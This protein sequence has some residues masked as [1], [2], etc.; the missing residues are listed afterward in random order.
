MKQSQKPSLWQTRNEL[1]SLPHGAAA[2]LMILVAALAGVFAATETTVLVMTLVTAIYAS[3]LLLYRSPLVLLPVPAA[4]LIAFFLYKSPLTALLS[5]AFAPCAAVIAVSVF[6][7]RKCF[8][9]TI[10]LTAVSL[11]VAAGCTALMLY[12]SFG[13][14]SEGITAVFA[15]IDQSL[16]DTWTLMITQLGA[17]NAAEYE[18]V[19]RSVTANYKFIL[20][21]A[22]ISTAMIASWAACKLTHR[23]LVWLH[24]DKSFFRKK[25]T[26]MVPVAW[27]YAYIIVTVSVLVVSLLLL[28]SDTEWPLYLITNL[29]AVTEPPLIAIG[30]RRFRLTL[31]R[32]RRRGFIFPYILLVIGLVAFACCMGVTF[33]PFLL[34]YTG[35][36]YVIRRHKAKKLKK[37]LE[38]SGQAPIWTAPAAPGEKPDNGAPD[39]GD[40]ADTTAEQQPD[41]PENDPDDD[42]DDG[43]SEN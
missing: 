34:A 9:T 23:I 24:A 5:L 28:T 25:W 31:R 11:A 38:E 16:A 43:D 37:M 10:T 22:V 12:L 33:L 6:R 29:L 15:A 13:S 1:P 42:S 36:M 7:R 40:N 19:W 35:A 27:A 18:E 26:V 8:R 32:L 41:A 2:A 4:Y 21:G 17:A 30:F 3:L 14:V 20:P 39:N